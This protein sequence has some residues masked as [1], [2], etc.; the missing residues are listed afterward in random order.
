M[1]NNVEIVTALY[2]AMG[3]GDIAGVRDR[4]DPEIRWR[5][6]EGNPYRPSGEAWVGVDAIMSNLFARLGEEWDGFA[7]HAQAFHDAGDVVVV[8]GRYTGLYKATGKSLDAQVCHV[9]T[10]KGGKVAE[11]QQYVDTAQCREVMSA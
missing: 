7:V 8:E 4:M 3:R 11:F 9:W 2:E 5:E 6:A 10:L 1:T